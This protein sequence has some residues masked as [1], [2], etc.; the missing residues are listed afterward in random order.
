MKKDDIKMA[1]KEQVQSLKEYAY[2]NKD[3]FP[4]A[5]KK[6]NGKNNP[7][8]NKSTSSKS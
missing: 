1:T 2:K 3:K 6:L 5:N 8:K 7:S 4:N